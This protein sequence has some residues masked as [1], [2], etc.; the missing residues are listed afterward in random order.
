MGMIQNPG[1][2]HRDVA[3]TPITLFK[4]RKYNH[5][6]ENDVPAARTVER[7]R[8]KLPVEIE[9]YIIGYLDSNDTE[10][11]RTVARCARVCR[12]WLPFSRYKLYYIVKIN[13]QIGRAHV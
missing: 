11:G 2:G 7:Q 13:W 8:I 3:D 5:V 1:P 9:E 6:V 4:R 12:A 10:S